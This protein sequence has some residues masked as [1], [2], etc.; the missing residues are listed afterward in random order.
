MNPTDIND[1]NQQDN[2]PKFETSSSTNLNSNFSNGSETIP[3]STGVL[4]LGILSICFCWCYGILSIIM[5]IIALVLY[6]AAKKQY[7]ANPGKYALA[8]FKNLNAGR[9]CA[10]I[11][12]SLSVLY[13]IALIIYV[14][15]V[16]SLAFNLFNNLNH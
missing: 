3:N 13:I 9:I 2:T 8:S 15:V 14:V 16:G 10:I 1:P 7:D 5:G 12:L 11:G 4:V 6:S